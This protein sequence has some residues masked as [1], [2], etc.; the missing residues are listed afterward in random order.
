MFKKLIAV[1]LNIPDGYNDNEDDFMEQLLKQLS[2][3]ET[4]IR[5][6]YL[7]GSGSTLN[8]Q[9]MVKDIFTGKFEFVDQIKGF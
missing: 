1:E 2:F 5:I 3:D 8:R 4:I 9:K 6:S 7:P